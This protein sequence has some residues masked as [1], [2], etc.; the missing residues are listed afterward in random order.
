MQSWVYLTLPE[1]KHIQ[2]PVNQLPRNLLLLLPLEKKKMCIFLFVYIPPNAPQNS[3]ENWKHLTQSSDLA[4]RSAH[5]FFLSPPVTN[6]ACHHCQKAQDF[7]SNHTLHCE[8]ERKI[9][10]IKWDTM[11]SITRIYN[12][13]VL[14]FLNSTHWKRSC[15]VVFTRC[16]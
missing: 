2:E 8:E 3:L 16:F 7:M 15:A 11:R 14:C 6:W 10:V 13:D 5:T 1:V 12:K 9:S 4:E